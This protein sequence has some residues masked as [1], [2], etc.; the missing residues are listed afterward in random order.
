[1]FPESDIPN[2][3]A[4]ALEGFLKELGLK[5][6]DKTLLEENIEIQEAEPGATILAEGSAD[7]S[8]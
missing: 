2:L 1:M 3:R 8:K 6:A 7:V 4:Y 5:E